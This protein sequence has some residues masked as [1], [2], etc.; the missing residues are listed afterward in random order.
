MY[1][2]HGSHRICDLFVGNSASA[3]VFSLQ[4]IRDIDY[5]IKDKLLMESI[6][7]VEFQDVSERGIFYNGKSLELYECADT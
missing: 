3:C 4:S 6:L 5:L 2:Q 7:D 1:K